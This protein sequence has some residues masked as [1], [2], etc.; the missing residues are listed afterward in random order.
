MLVQ[1][2]L[3]LSRH[4]SLSSIA[5]GRSSRLHDMSVLSSGR[6]VQ[7]GCPTAARSCEGIPWRTSLMS[8]LL[9][10]QGPACLVRLIR[11]SNATNSS[12]AGKVNF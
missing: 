6:Y 2:S 10:P 11:N 8:S 7:A 3:T 12:T 1:I 9:L 4:S 5:S